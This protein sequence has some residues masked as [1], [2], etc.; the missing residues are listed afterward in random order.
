MIEVKM[1]I[2]EEQVRFR[3]AIHDIKLDRPLPPKT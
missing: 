3:D 2:N 1:A